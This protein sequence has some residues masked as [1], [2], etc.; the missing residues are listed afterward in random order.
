MNSTLRYVGLDVHKATIAIAVAEGQGGE[1][2]VVSTIPNEL[3][4]LLKHLGRLG[5]PE[6]LHCCYEAGPTGYGVYRELR[7]QGIVCDVVAPSLVPVQAGNRVKTDRR[8]AAK[9]ARYS[10]TA[11]LFHARAQLPS[12]HTG[13]LTA[14]FSLT[15]PASRS[16]RRPRRWQSSATFARLCQ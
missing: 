1:P 8:D 10:T 6:S 4:I 3:S 13:H 9:L 15:P 7:A 14:C 2:Q 11:P 12:S 5:C 16:R